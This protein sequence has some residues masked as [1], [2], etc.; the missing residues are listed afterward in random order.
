MTKQ[1]ILGLI[2]LALAAP[3]FAGGQARPDAAGASASPAPAAA[4]P[5]ECHGDPVE[6]STH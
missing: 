6:C 2:S 4:A 5:G 3:A 1:L